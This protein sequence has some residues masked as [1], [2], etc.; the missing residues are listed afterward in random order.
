VFDESSWGHS[1]TWSAREI[2]TMEQ[3]VVD[4]SPIVD[5]SGRFHVVYEAFEAIEQTGAHIGY[6]VRGTPWFPGA[7]PSYHLFEAGSGGTAS[8]PTVCIEGSQG[9]LHAAYGAK[10]TPGHPGGWIA[11][12]TRLLAASSDSA[13]SAVS[14]AT[15]AW[16]TTTLGSIQPESGGK[17]PPIVVD[18]SGD[19]HFFGKLRHR[20]WTP[21]VG[22]DTTFVLH[23]WGTPSSSDN[24]ASNI[25]TLQTFTVLTDSV[26]GVSEEVSASLVGASSALGGSE[27][28]DV[29]WGVPHAEADP[30]RETY[31]SRVE[32][33]TTGAFLDAGTHHAERRGDVAWGSPLSHAG[34]AGALHVQRGSGGRR[35]GLLHVLGHADG[36]DEVVGSGAGDAGRC[37]RDV[38]TE[39]RRAGRQPVG[40]LQL[41]GDRR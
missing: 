33:D 21:G 31:F 4:C 20:S 9:V 37:E 29:V 3:G 11:H 17:G 26:P 18:G 13:W 34:R 38:G 24:W 36:P 19:V 14:F 23:V 41:A 25:A 1:A 40:A 16:S 30:I 8:S 27:S 15:D 5:P 7:W 6:K 32:L 2:Y 22:A 12:R 35:A 10:D 39:L 28:I